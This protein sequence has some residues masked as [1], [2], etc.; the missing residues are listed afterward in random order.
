MSSVSLK[1]V[2]IAAL[3]D[4]VTSSVL[5]AILVSA[6]AVWSGAESAD[7]V[8]RFVSSSSIYFLTYAVG[9]VVSVVAGYMA[10]KIARRGELVNGALSSFLCV[11]LGVYVELSGASTAPAA[12][13]ITSL[14]LSPL[15]GSLG[16]YLRLRRVATAV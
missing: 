12:L 7:D 11:L 1:A 16:G 5:G 2:L 6:G 3:F 13:S 8:A 4:V 15:L 14:A 9:S 10:A